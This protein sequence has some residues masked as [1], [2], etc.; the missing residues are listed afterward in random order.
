M[1]NLLRH[2]MNCGFI[3]FKDDTNFVLKKVATPC[4]PRKSITDTVQSDVSEIKFD[5]Y[6]EAIQAAKKLV[7]FKG[8][9]VEESKCAKKVYYKVQMCYMHKELP[10]VPWVEATQLAEQRAQEFA[11]MNDMIESWEV[12]VYPCLR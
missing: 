11:E 12:K 6:S 8:D 1:E 3:I 2:L 7:D 4:D 10:N 5:D 9:I